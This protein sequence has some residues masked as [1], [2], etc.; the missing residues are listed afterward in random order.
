[1]LK[2]KTKIINTTEQSETNTKNKSNKNIPWGLSCQCPLH[3]EPQ[4]TLTLG[5]P[6]TLLARSLDLLW[7]LC[8]SLIYLPPVLLLLKLYWSQ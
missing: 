2:I 1:M 8:H 3:S 7:A 5:G 6:S 4:L